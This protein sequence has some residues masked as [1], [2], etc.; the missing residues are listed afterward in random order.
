[1]EHAF[2]ADHNKLRKDTDEFD[3]GRKVVGKNR[4]GETESHCMEKADNGERQVKANR[5][6]E[7]HRER[8]REWESKWEGGSEEGRRK[9]RKGG[10]N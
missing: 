3:N 10:G 9:G 6:N 4:S 5:K 7:T 1:M 8:K 2:Q